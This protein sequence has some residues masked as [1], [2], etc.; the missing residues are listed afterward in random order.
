L[1]RAKTDWGQVR[2]R[3]QASQ[4][5]LERALTPTSERIEDVYRRRAVRLALVH[6]QYQPAATRLPVL[7]CHAAQERCAI[8]TKNVAEVLPFVRCVPVPGAPQHILGVIN[9]R[10]ELR[11]VAD[12]G[13][14]L[15]PG[16]ESGNSGFV[17]MLRNQGQTTG[18]GEIG[19]K[20]DR[21]EGVLEV[22]PQEWIAT[23]H[24]NFGK[25]L[26]SGTLMLVDIEKLLAGLVRLDEELL[27]T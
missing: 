20:V 22:M 8:D 3:M 7:I 25:G 1:K 23:A 9:L 4:A 13:R 17:L 6:Q 15:N 18:R 5:A 24:G 2:N 26:V 14:L 12:L 16:V 19:L 21:I 11:A 27:V 10:G